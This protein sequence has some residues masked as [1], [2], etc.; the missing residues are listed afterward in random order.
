MEADFAA[1]R[2]KLMISLDESRTRLT[3]Y[4]A[5]EVQIDSTVM[6]VA[7]ANN[8]SAVTITEEP[9]LGLP[10]SP[11]RRI[12]QA[13]FLAQ[14]LLRVEQEKNDVIVE[15]GKLKEELNELKNQKETMERFMTRAAQPT[16]YLV[17]KLEE[18]EKV[19]AHS[20]KESNSLT[21][22][23]D[24]WKSQCQLKEKEVLELHQRLEN[25][26]KHRGELE[27]V[28]SMI[29]HLHDGSDDSESDEEREGEV[30]INMQNAINDS[31]DSIEG[32]LVE[33]TKSGLAHAQVESEEERI[34]QLSSSLGIPVEMVKSM[35]I[36]PSH[37]T[38]SILINQEKTFKLLP[39]T[40]GIKQVSYERKILSK[41]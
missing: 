14:K 23:L 36:P 1:E 5:L 25:L 11:E 35:L 9:V 2:Q 37:G 33:K 34:Q 7:K 28:R 31:T 39:S 4:E 10:T 38:K 12:R 17:S 20:R 6:R 40:I 30:E 13:V 15:L 18:V 19:L 16:S 27:A 21:N 32:T 3:A 29:E 41:E 24:Y 26:L 22:Q 8:D